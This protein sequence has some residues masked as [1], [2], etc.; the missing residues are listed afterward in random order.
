MNADELRAINKTDIPEAAKKLSKTDI[1]SL[2]DTLTEK[3][4]LLRYHA[5]LMLQAHSRLSPAVYTYWAVLESKLSNS[6]S[7][8]RSLGL[9][10]LAEN[11][12]WDKDGKFAKVIDSYMDGC[13]DAKFITARQAIQGL[14][15]II[16][17]TSSYN[18]KIQKRL[19]SID[20]SKY[21][22][23]QQSLLRKDVANIQKLLGKK[24]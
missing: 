17:A 1:A 8:Q 23:N 14:A 13:M 2:V 19:A 10:L 11:V 6:N 16:E 12:R 5:F 15:N 21:K 7:Y 20:F 4:D 22:E 24:C 3:D 18:D 9:M